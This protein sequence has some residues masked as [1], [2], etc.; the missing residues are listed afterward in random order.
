MADFKGNG[1]ISSRNGDKHHMVDRPLPQARESEEVVLGAILLNGDT[2]KTVIDDLDPKYFYVDAHQIIYKVMTHLFEDKQA[3]NLTTVSEE[4]N[5]SGKLKEVGGT[6]YL[7]T[8]T[9]RAASSDNLDKHIQLI[10]EKF[11][12][13]GMIYLGNMINKEAYKSTTN[14][15]ELIDKIQQ[16]YLSVAEQKPDRSDISALAAYVMLL[17]EQMEK[18]LKQGK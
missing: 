15:V 14:G 1:N 17:V 11:I 8:L 16:V 13:R 2:L 5:K 9:N 10:S 3:V 12:N 6:S 18:A 7:T 4:L